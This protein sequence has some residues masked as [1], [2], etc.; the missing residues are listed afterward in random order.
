MIRLPMKPHKTSSRY[1]R[2]T[3]TLAVMT[4]VAGI[5][6]S[7]QIRARIAQSE[8]DA[9][10][11]SAETLRLNTEQELALF[12][13]VLESV[14]ALHALS[15]AI[16]Q[17]AMDEFIEKGL[18][19]QQTVLGAFGLAQRVSPRMR[20]EIESKARPAPG[21]YDIVETGPDGGWVPAETRPVYYPLTWQSHAGALN[22]PV[23]YD[24]SSEPE[25]RRVIAGIERTRRTVL[26]PEPVALPSDTRPPKAEA[27]RMRGSEA[28]NSTLDTRHPTLDTRPPTPDTAPSYWVFAPVVP[29]SA[30]VGVIGLAVA[31]LHPDAIFEKVAGLAAAPPHL[32]LTPV[33]RRPET[34][35]RLE[36]NAWHYS[37]PLEAIGT[38]WSFECSL[39][40]SMSDRRSSAVFATGL[41]ITALMTTLL[42]ILAGRTRRIEAEVLTRTEELRVANL[43]LEENLR[44]RALMEEEMNEL[45][46]RERRRIG[47]DLHDSLGQKLTGAAFLSR[48]LLNWFQKAE[49]GNWKLE[50]GNLKLE[51]GNWKLETRNSETENREAEPQ[52][53]A[54]SEETSPP[55]ISNQQSAIS[56]QLTHAKTLN[57][58]LKSAVSQV[59]S[60]A[61]GLASVTLNEESLKE[62]LEQLADE[63]S[64]LYDTACTV[65]FSGPLPELDRKTKEQLYFIAREAVNNA[66]RHARPGHITIQLCSAPSGWTLRIDDDGSGFP[67][68]QVAGEGMGLRIMRH[69][70]TRIGAAF[71]I[72]SAP[73]SGTSIEVQS[74]P[75]PQ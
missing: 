1:G 58:T 25:A 73:G 15:G 53:S 57:D 17:A 23:G 59:R 71:A 55:A 39:P 72:R 7:L 65:S 27:P 5:A 20:A 50:T 42:L 35:I 2:W 45:S 56:N 13:E 64:S 41:V 40:V 52:N 36:N 43:R 14:R 44:E 21:A 33:T 37:G 54:P 31:V 28:E 32:R 8:A 70:A 26:V 6:I 67:E 9:A 49:T 34:T 69:R 38:I 74:A 18:V 68:N 3:L 61:R 4:A 47:R 63:M 10:R 16:D 29:R 66:A 19:H 75:P 46:A 11:L 51:T 24:F 48:A 62:S 30:P 12:V 60:M 22:V